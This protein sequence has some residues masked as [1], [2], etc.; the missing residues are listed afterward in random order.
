M[1]AERTVFILDPTAKP[2]AR[3]VDITSQ[4]HDLN[5]KVIGFLDSGKPNGDILLQRIE[6]QL[7]KRYQLAGSIWQRKP[8]ARDFADPV[9][10][11][12]LVTPCD[13]VINALGD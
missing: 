1:T 3:E 11:D 6:E 4:V 2:T 7:S 13:V 12:K 10:I 9:V 5:G 8:S